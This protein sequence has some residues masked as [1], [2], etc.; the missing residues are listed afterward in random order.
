LEGI[1][2]NLLL[3]V[4]SKEGILVIKAIKLSAICLAIAVLFTV[5]SFSQ[6]TKTAAVESEQV[7]V[8][9]RLRDAVIMYTGSPIAFLDGVETRIDSS[10]SEIAPIIKDNIRLVP[11]RFIA[12]SL[13]AEVQWDGKT[14]TAV[15]RFK[16]KTVKFKQYSDIITDGRTTW[17]LDAPVQAVEGRT[18]VAL[19]QLAGILGKEVFYDR[20]LIVISNAKDIFDPVADKETVN[21]WISRLSFLPVVGSYDELVELLSRAE[22]NKRVSADES[23]SAW[24]IQDVTTVNKEKMDDSAVAQKSPKAVES[25]LGT[26]MPGTLPEDYS[27]TN[28]QVQGVDEADIVKTDGK[29]IYQVNRGRV[30]VARAYPAEEMKIESIIDF[31]GKNF[32]PI[33]LYID[34]QRLAVIGTTC[35]NI[36]LRVDR[37]QKADTSIYPPPRYYSQTV[38]II[39]YDIEDRRDI[40]KLRELEVEGNYISSRKIASQLYLVANKHI[41]YYYIQRE[42]GNITPSYR[43][44][45]LKDDFIGIDYGSIRYFPDTVESSYMIIAGMDLNKNDE[46]ADISTYLGAGQNIYS[47]GENL[48]VAVSNYSS[49]RQGLDKDSPEEAELFIMPVYRYDTLVYKFS[50]NNGKV[51]YLA[52]GKVPGTIL[53]QFS[54]DENEGFFRIATT[55]GDTWRSDEYTSQNNVYILDEMLNITG[56]IENIAPGERIYSVRF[57]GDRG[58]VVTFKTVDPLFV[59]DLKDPENPSILGALKIPGYSDYLHPYDEN[60][61]IGFGKDTVDIKGQAYYLGMKLAIFDVTDVNN[62]VQKFSEIIGGRGTESELLR[63]HKALLFSKEKGLMAFPVTVME[64]AENSKK[65][66][67][68]FLDYGEF[69]FQGAYVYNV[70]L[71]NGFKLKG[72]ITHLSEEDYLKAGN[73]WYDSSKNIR[74]IIY[75]GD[76]LYS[77]SDSMLTAHGLE[78]MKEKN[79]VL[80]P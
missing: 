66:K 62:P 47:S 18:Y 68:G 64:T 12:E 15:V 59:I 55:R 57:M 77:L 46:A 27:H 48:Y 17:K 21:E 67:A 36:P 24:G 13:G 23:E 19:E 7:S 40:K 30:V 72:K 5:F 54:M 28:I 14:G 69:K 70:D 56:K 1:P 32:T 6:I 29:Y 51:T 50:L 78:S 65:A 38:K 44:S 31:T 73:Y 49:E 16:D 33:E 43:D 53:N 75:I 8:E 74:R 35:D 20:G 42:E 26:S 11:L 79:R 60:H 25:N 71:V 41:D 63:D 9:D 37:N 61:I 39:V 80:I 52:K 58:Y 76:S 2:S 22:D 4:N 34:E 45:T 10:N 3:K